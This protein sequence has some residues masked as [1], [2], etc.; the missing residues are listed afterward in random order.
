MGH[1]QT[2][3]GMS[4]SKGGAD[5]IQLEFLSIALSKDWAQPV[6][7]SCIYWYSASELLGSAG[8]IGEISEP[9]NKFWGVYI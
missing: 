5:A 1:P 7:W 6:Q 2:V 3:S 8:S 9:D 4:M